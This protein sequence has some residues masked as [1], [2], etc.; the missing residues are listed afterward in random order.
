MKTIS[1]L[2]CEIRSMQTELR[3]MDEHLNEI[4]DE[5]MNYKDSGTGKSDY[6]KIYRVVQTMPIIEHPIIKYGYES[7]NNYFAILILVATCEDSINNEQKIFLQ[8]M[9]MADSQRSTIDAYLNGISTINIE[10]VIFNIHEDIKHNLAKQLVLDMIII[11]NLSKIQTEKTF[12]LITN[13]AAFL[14]IDSDDLIHISNIA[15]TILKQNIREYRNNIN[16]ATI[17]G[18]EES[19]GYYLN[20]VPGWNILIN[21]ERK[22][23]MEELLSNVK[24]SGKTTSKPLG[25]EMSTKE[26]YGEDWYYYE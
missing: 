9:I 4:S 16:K 18:D 25:A 14:E 10:N 23:L 20:E 26:E 6:E 19:F 21:Q 7:K 13:I 15:L 11:A 3:N 17:I 22:R 12:G 1:E 24:N 2:Q 8:R 5:L